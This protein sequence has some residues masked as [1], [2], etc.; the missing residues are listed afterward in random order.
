MSRLSLGCVPEF[1]HSSP[2][3]SVH[4]QMAST[5]APELKNLALWPVTGSEG[6]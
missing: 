4:A 5:P 1:L 2:H 6:R 3:T